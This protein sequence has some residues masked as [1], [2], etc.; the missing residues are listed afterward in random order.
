MTPR[1][2][3]IYYPYGFSIASDGTFWISQPNSQNIIHV[4][5]QR[6]RARQLLDGR[7]HARE[8]RR[9]GPMAMSTSPA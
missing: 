7:H 4:D 5:A 6:Q 2:T 3:A 9:S 1:T 8:R